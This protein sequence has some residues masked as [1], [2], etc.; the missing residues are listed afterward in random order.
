MKDFT[1][2]TF[3]LDASG[4]MNHIREDVIGS[5]KT[6]IAEQ[7]KLGDNF[8]VD[9]YMFNTVIKHMEDI[10]Q[11]CCMGTTA[12]IDA[13]CEVIDKVGE[14]LNNTVDK[15]DKVVIVIMTDGYENASV[16]FSN[17]DLKNRIE[18]QQNTY[19]W[20]FV[21]LGSNIDSFATAGSYGI[22]MNTTGN[23]VASSAGTSSAVRSLSTSISNYRKGSGSLKI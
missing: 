22:N 3:I 21:F 1:D 11:Y 5:Y 9:A 6:F 18:L 13:V 7:Q 19:K 2:I 8:S 16:K 17:D 10:K 12:L 14:R 4:S 23:F 20:S 15:P